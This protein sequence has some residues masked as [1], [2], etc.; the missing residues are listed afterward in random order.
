MSSLDRQLLVKPSVQAEN[1]ARRR[2][3]SGRAGNLWLDF[4]WSQS[5]LVGFLANPFM[6]PGKQTPVQQAILAIAAN[7]YKLSRA[8]D[9]VISSGYPVQAVPLVRAVYERIAI[10]LRVRADNHLAQR[11]LSGEQSR[12]DTANVVAN[13]EDDVE[14]LAA[15]FMEARGFA[16][17]PTIDFSVLTQNV[18]PL[19][20][21]LSSFAHPGREAISNYFL[22]DPETGKAVFG[23]LPEAT[24]S[25]FA[26][27]LLLYLC[28]MQFVLKMIL[29]VDFAA[30]DDKLWQGL[31]KI[32]AMWLSEFSDRVP[33]YRRLIEPYTSQ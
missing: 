5:Q 2:F 14:P 26:I 3:S 33:L 20:G 25:R 12:S 28:V 27:V 8:A 21:Q 7:C 15:E 22:V 19:Y 24:A 32:H 11:L 23:Y 29:T 1:K 30:P 16:Q 13:W 4:R 6:L 31:V 17:F 9:L 18:G 10:A